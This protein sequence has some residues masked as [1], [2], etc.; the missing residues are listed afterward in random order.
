MYVEGPEA[1][2]PLSSGAGAPQM[3]CVP[4]GWSALGTAATEQPDGALE[5]DWQLK[6]LIKQATQRAF[7]LLSHLREVS[8]FPQRENFPHR[9]KKLKLKLPESF[10]S[11]HISFHI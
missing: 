4:Q 8:N 7:S 5:M 9:L 6:T 3:G 1:R 2:A 10:S 11:F